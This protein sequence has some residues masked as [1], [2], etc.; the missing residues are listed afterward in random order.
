MDVSVSETTTHYV[1]ARSTTS[2]G[3][4]G[5]AIQ[6]M[7][8]LIGATVRGQKLFEAFGIEE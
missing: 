5:A 1:L 4:S 2:Q 7:N 6:C 8:I 3:P